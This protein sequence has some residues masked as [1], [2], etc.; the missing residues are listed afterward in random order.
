MFHSWLFAPAPRLR[1]RAVS[2]FL[3]VLA[4]LGTLLGMSGCN[5]TT[6]VPSNGQTVKV[7][8]HLAQMK[9]ASGQTVAATVSCDPGETLV[10]GGYY[11]TQIVPGLAAVVLDSYPSDG[12]GT[13]P[14]S[15]GQAETAWTVRATNPTS[16]QMAY[17]ISANCLKGIPIKTGVWFASFVQKDPNHNDSF[18]SAACT[19]SHESVLTGGGFQSALN[20][21]VSP[22]WGVVHAYPS[23]EKGI[24]HKLWHL[25]VFGASGAIYA[26]CA[27]GIFAEPLV[28]A[29]D[30]T[31][32]LIKDVSVTC[33]EDEVL[34]GGGFLQPGAKGAGDAIII[35]TTGIPD[36]TA[37]HAGYK[38]DYGANLEVDGICVQAQS[39]FRISITFS[40]YRHLLRIPA[41]RVTVATDGSGQV[42]ASQVSARVTQAQ[43]GQIPAIQTTNPFTGG[44][45]YVVPAGCGDPAP[46]I[47]AATNALKTQLGALVPAVQLPFGAPSISINRGSLTCSPG[48]GTQRSAPFTYVQAIDGS[49]T[50]GTYSPDDVRAYQRGQ[51]DQAVR[52][53]G[54]QYTLDNALIC[55][56]GTQVASATATQASILCP[57]GG[58]VEWGWTSDALKALARSLAGKHTDEALRLL[59][60]TPGVEPGT[61]IIEVPSNGSATVIIRPGDTLPS[62]PNAII[63]V[64]IPLY[65]PSLLLDLT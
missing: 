62:D 60:T 2:A 64:V 30:F 57:A 31:S 13:A 42:K 41:D 18:V 40:N 16:A 11:S 52:A 5:L 26:V 8:Q 36:L 24:A 55:P 51:L 49:A 58:V 20:G 37:W 12:S 7:V 59:D 23:E 32:Q 28:D 29:Q 14:S 43:S 45:S 17:F 61:S 21:L 19:D 25:G 48:P 54:G 35:D 15:Q 38:S 39:T 44:V 10:S 63:V 56:Q 22:Q 27:Q 47:D 33:P 50:Q 1:A 34:V 53:L 3:L 4:L 46:A 9:V 65:E 6:T